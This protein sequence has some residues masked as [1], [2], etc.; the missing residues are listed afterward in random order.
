M[1]IGPRLKSA[2]GLWACFIAALC[3]W[4]LLSAEK[5]PP[6]PPAYFNDYAGV[7]KP[8]T[9]QQLERELADFERRT[10]VQIVVAIFKRLPE[11]AALEDFTQRTAA[12]WKVGRKGL[13]NGAVLFAFI[14]DRRLR[15]EVGYGLE[16]AIPD[17]IAK[18]ITSEQI[19][20]HFQR[21]DYDAGITA[22]VNALMQAAQGE[23]QGTGR[24]VSQS[25]SSNVQTW[26]PFL[27]FGALFL[28]I[29]WRSFRRRSRGTTFSRRGR[30]DWGAWPILT[31]G[32]GGGGGSWSGGGGGGGFSGGGGDFG[33]GGASDSW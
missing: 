15:I 3:A 13:N 21:G 19:R 32:W 23:Y 24:T 8:G 10:S 22:G 20:P 33:G 27:I 1:R 18:R 30:S 25:H 7:T 28:A 5:L 17:A 4:P 6:S 12:S 16:G 29:L 9:G 2:A 26:W 11:N 14:E 31:S